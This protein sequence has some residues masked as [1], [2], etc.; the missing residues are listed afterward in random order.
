MFDRVKVKDIDHPDFD[1][2]HISDD[3]QTK[4]L[5][6]NLTTFLIKNN[7]LFKLSEFILE[8]EGA[9]EEFFDPPVPVDFTGSLII[10]ANFDDDSPQQTST[11]YLLKFKDGTVSDVSRSYEL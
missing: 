6:C 10:Y 11:E 1:C 7:R 8:P 3:Y 2:D 4:C 5:V 9:I